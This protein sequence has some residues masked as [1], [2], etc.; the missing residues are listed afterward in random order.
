MG[1]KVKATLPKD[2]ELNGLDEQA[3]ADILAEPR[4]PRVAIVVLQT[5]E[6]IKNLA[7]GTV[8]PKLRIDRIE[9]VSDPEEADQLV[10]RAQ[11]LSEQRTGKTAL[12]GLRAVEPVDV[13]ESA[14]DLDDGGD[15]A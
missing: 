9:L 12:P 14:L 15:A 8:T 10:R 4:K 1:V 2:D 5:E 6:E 13:D 11:A 3:A 7:N